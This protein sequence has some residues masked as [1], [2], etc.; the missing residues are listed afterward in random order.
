MMPD[1]D[2]DQVL[3]GLRAMA[4]MTDLPVIMV[5][6]RD[7]TSDVVQA[8]REGAN[9]Y[10]TKPID[11]PVLVARLQTHLSLRRLASL[12]DEFC[13]IASHDLKSP[14][15]AMIVAA[16]VLE[17]RQEGCGF[18]DNVRE[19]IA[20]FKNCTHTMQRII[21]DF[22]DFEAM[23]NGSLALAPQAVHLGDLVRAAVGQQHEVARNK[24]I[25]IQVEVEDLHA[26]QG[27]AARLGQVIQ[28]LLSNAV[29][30]TPSE[31][32]VVARARRDSP[33]HVLCEVI[34]SGP[35][36]TGEDLVLLFNKRARLTAQP[37]GGE[38]S[39]GLGL[40]S[41]SASN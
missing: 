23:E 19:M 31:G 41:T 15:T 4:P 24:S 9:D 8:L 13:A 18:D 11:F 21:E 38:K 6:A 40:Y 28:N 32:L 1:V 16:H 25:R 14:L 30:F 7:Q 36:L 39:T 29:K 20:L 33:G 3:R 37:T 35:G 27:D 34:D 22:L 5:T 2:G 10:V 12:K 26:V 17:R